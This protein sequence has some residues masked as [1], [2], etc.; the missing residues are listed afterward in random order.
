MPLFF[1]LHLGREQ[2]KNPDNNDL[3]IDPGGGPIDCDLTD[4]RAYIKVY[5]PLSS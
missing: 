3:N 5:S 2:L 4:I 1:F